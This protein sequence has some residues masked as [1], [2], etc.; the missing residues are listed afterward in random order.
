MRYYARS[1]LNNKE[2][3]NQTLQKY[4]IA[5]IKTQL[6]CENFFEKKKFDTVILNHGIYIPQGIIHEVSKRKKK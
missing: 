6:S 5:A 2:K 3:A 1:D 4:L